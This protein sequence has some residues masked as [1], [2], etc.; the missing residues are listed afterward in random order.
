MGNSF[1]VSDRREPSAG[2]SLRGRQLIRSQPQGCGLRRALRHLGGEGSN[3]QV[4]VKNK[5]SCRPRRTLLAE[6][7]SVVTYEARSQAF[8]TKT[9]SL[10]IYRC[11][12]LFKIIY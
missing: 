5:C 12:L 7:G 1:L 11:V 3:L 4:F 10:S 8:R 2:P 6:S 9:D